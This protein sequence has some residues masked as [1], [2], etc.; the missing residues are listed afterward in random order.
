M[1][2][3]ASCAFESGLRG[4]FEGTILTRLSACPARGHSEGRAFVAIARSEATRHFLESLQGPR[5]EAISPV[6][7]GDCFALLAMTI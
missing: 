7:E 5:V 3:I 1:E 4:F 2:T 6:N